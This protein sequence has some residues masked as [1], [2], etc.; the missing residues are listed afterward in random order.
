MV[1]DKKETGGPKPAGPEKTID[2]R[3][4]RTRAGARS[5]D[6]RV[7]VVERLRERTSLRRREVPGANRRRHEPA[8]QR[9]S[10]SDRGRDRTCVGAIRDVQLRRD[11]LV[12]E[13]DQ[14]V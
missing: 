7:E 2:D 14:A 1:Q 8:N 9:I 13:D 12:R 5:G 4:L 3:E 10:R 11:Q 6:T